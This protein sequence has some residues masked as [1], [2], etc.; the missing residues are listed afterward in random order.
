MYDW[1]GGNMLTRFL[2]N[3]NISSSLLAYEGVELKSKVRSLLDH[4]VP[5]CILA[6]SLDLSCN[7]MSQRNQVCNLETEIM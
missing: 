3:S 5:S 4:L 1:G 7:H 6:R 2:S